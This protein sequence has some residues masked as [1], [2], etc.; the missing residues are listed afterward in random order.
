ME[1]PQEKEISTEKRASLDL[2]TAG[3]RKVN[4]IWEGNQAIIAIA[5][6]GVT[7]VVSAFLSMMVIDKDVNDRQLAIATTAFMLIGN[8]SSLVIGFYFGRTNHQ[9][10]GGVGSNESGR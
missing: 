9:K 4:L 6:V 10:V 2:T 7:L 5:V 1:P 3:Q 8:L